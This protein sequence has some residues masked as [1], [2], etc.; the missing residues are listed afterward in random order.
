MKA[1][2]LAVER[3]VEFDKD[4]IAALKAKGFKYDLGE[5]LTG[6]QMKYRRR[7]GGYYL[8]VGCSGLIIKGE[9]GL[10][11]WDNIECFVA[12]GVKLKDGSLIEA[13]LLVLATGYH[14]QR[15][16]VRRLLGEEVAAV[17]V[18]KP[19]HTLTLEQLREFLA[20]S[21]AKHKIPAT[22]WFR[23]EPIPR[24]ANGK[25]LKRELRKELVEG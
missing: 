1:Y 24:N 11:Q 4:L 23:T 5:D 17:L 6:H 15:E 9:V 20:A 22:V 14:T 25:F 7:G 3:M 2:Q 16:L 10:L 21:I 8:D 18:L 12:N 19:G 13:E